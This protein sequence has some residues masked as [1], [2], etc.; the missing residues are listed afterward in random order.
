MSMRKS[1]FL[2]LLAVLVLVQ[3]EQCMPWGLRLFLGDTY[4]NSSGTND[5]RI[6]FNTD[7]LTYV[8]RIVAQTPS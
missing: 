5:L 8:L 3:G 7:V 4:M 1:G 6:A 2:I